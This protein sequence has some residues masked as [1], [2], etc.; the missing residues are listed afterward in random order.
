MRSEHFD[1]RRDLCHLRTIFFKAIDS[2]SGL[3][4]DENKKK[5]N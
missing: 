5:L 1:N 2:R 3:R 4:K